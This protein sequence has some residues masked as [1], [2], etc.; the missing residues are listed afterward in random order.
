MTA[1]PVQ[2]ADDTT[3]GA[4]IALTALGGTIVSPVEPKDRDPQ[5]GAKNLLDGYPM[6]RGIEDIPNSFGWKPN[7]EV[8]KFPYELVIAFQAKR[9]ATLAEVVVDT[10]SADNILGPAGLPK[11]IE[12]WASTRS[13]TDG[14]TQVASATLPQNAGENV[15]KL[16]HV[17]AT[18]VKLVVKTSYDAGVRP[19]LGEVSI[20]EAA[21]APSIVAD[22]PKNLL[23][24]ALGGSIAR[25]SSQERQGEA[26]HLV[27]GFV[28]P[29]RGWCSG[30][31]EAEHPVLF[32]HEISFAFRDHRTANIDRIVISPKSGQL[33]VTPTTDTWAKT[34]EVQTSE[35]SPWDGFT[36][37]KTL[38]VGTDGNPITVPVGKPIRYIR[39]R[40]LDNHGNPRTTLGEV[41]AFEAPGKSLVA[42]RAVPLL[43]LAAS[44]L[45]AGGETA[46]RREKEPNNSVAEGDHLTTPDPVGGALTPAGDRDVFIVP[47]AAK[48]G[49]QTVT[50]SVEGRPAIRSRISVVDAGGVTRYT[51]DPAVLAA[52]TTKFSVV[53]DAGDVALQVVQPPAAQ[54]VIWDSSGSMVDRVKDLD[55]AL[56]AYMNQ[57]APTDRVQ[58]IRFDDSIEVLMKSFSSDKTAL[59]AALKD[60]V[61]A[62]GG[63]SIYDAIGKGIDSLDKI[64][65]SRALLLLTDG[66]DTT[67]Q[68]DPSVFWRR[69][70]QA[71]ARLYAIGLGN[72]L[73]DYVVRAGATAERVLADAALETGGRYVFV[74]DSAKLGA[75]YAQIGDELRASATYAIAAHA[76]TGNGTITVKSIG[77]QLAVPPRVELVLDASGSM[78]RKAG[79]GSMMDAA[80]SVLTDVVTQLPNSAT[81][82]L[83]VY[84]HRTPE[85]KPDACHDSELVVPFGNLDRKALTTK[86]KAVKALGTT[87]IAYSIEQVGQDLKD[88][89]GPSM[90]IIVT[91]GKEECGGDPQAAIAALRKSGIDVSLN[92]VGFSLTDAGDRDV[93]TKVAAAGNGQF[94]DAKGATDLKN[95]V[96]QS[97]AVPYSIVDA[98]GAVVGH[99]LVGGPAVTAPAGDMSIRLDTA[100]TPVTIDHVV[101]A[102]NKATSVQLDK[103]GDK[104]GAKISAPGSAL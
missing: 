99:G 69:L 92:I 101:V 15:I 36:T 96:V 49:K 18:Y 53:T 30:P 81:V 12:L 11:D 70:K 19:Q 77:D 33:Y 90:L 16:D 6:I 80:K 72:G 67:S 85:G 38:T 100:S 48:A 4:N 34:I 28:D 73:R 25:F 55:T 52:P 24:P 3:L 97:L 10:A 66:E 68:T 54:V 1:E 14:F 79:A 42:G 103:D 39:L 104:V 74:A 61:Y 91:D 57:L 47:A 2:S 35:T 93:M 20:Y 9:E 29:Q 59:T 71:N 56:H 82:G 88:V 83:R 21:D 51:L 13:A 22:V 7:D 86:I 75:M 58:L 63:T 64:D 95:A 32:P 23:L 46:S 37:L 50:V 102:P 84:G 87:P 89:N 26:Y 40:I 45:A 31:N 43:G 5:W 8:P 44:S 41:E 94:F 76:E 98:T 62:D 17:H 78:K 27:D 60:K 65:G